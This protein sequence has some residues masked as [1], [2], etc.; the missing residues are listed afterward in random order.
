MDCACEMFRQ[1]DA[2]EMSYI[3]SA[4][5]AAAYC[6]SFQSIETPNEQNKLLFII[7]DC[8]ARWLL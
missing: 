3:F 1:K 4:A 5:A 7:A 6:Y 2:L 8:T